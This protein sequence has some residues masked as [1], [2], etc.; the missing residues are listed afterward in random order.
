MKVRHEH[1]QSVR[2]GI[3]R[4]SRYELA[5]V[6]FQIKIEIVARVGINDLQVC[7]PHRQ[8]TETQSSSPKIHTVPRAKVRRRKTPSVGRVFVWTAS[9]HLYDLVGQIGRASCR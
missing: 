4:I 7:I 2:E 9:K 8:L 1:G 6:L 3:L 5:V